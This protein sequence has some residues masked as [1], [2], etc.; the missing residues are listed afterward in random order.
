MEGWAES[1]VLT[2]VLKSLNSIRPIMVQRMFPR[3][4]FLSVP[5]LVKPVCMLT[6][7]SD[8]L[9]PDR[10]LHKTFSTQWCS[11]QELLLPHPFHFVPNHPYGR[12]Q[13]LITQTH[14][15]SW[16]LVTFLNWIAGIPTTGTDISRDTPSHGKWNLLGILG[17][18]C[19]T[20]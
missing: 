1:P 6:C 14:R 2:N 10:H 16:S 13:S 9:R 5:V 15:G 8:S 7:G 19:V 11:R 17:C 12:N 20:T 3:H 18:C 4:W